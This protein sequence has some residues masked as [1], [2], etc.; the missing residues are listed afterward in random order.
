MNT[1]KYCYTVDGNTK[2]EVRG[3]KRC[4]LT[5]C[6]GTRIIVRWP[7]GHWTVPCLRGCKE[8]KDGVIIQ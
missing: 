8:H 2:G 1:P 5:G 7:D 3:T 4:T 6:G